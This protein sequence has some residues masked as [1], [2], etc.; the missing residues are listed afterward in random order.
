MLHTQ[1]TFS[2]KDP[3][4][5][6]P[7]LVPIATA[8]PM[9]LNHFP[10]LRNGTRSVTIISDSVVIPPAPMPW[11]ERPTS[12][13]SSCCAMPQIIAPAVKKTSAVIRSGFLPNMEENA[14]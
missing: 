14:A 12:K 10:R 7:T 13:T 9:K 1:D 4:T 6:G 8:A 5:T 2:A 3:P 11:I